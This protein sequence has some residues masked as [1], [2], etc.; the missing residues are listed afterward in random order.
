MDWYVLVCWWYV[1]GLLVIRMLAPYRRTNTCRSYVL[2]RNENNG[3]QVLIRRVRQRL[4]STRT[5]E[6]NGV[7]AYCQRISSSSRRLQVR[8]ISSTNRVNSRF[9]HRLLRNLSTRRVLFFSNVRSV[10]RNRFLVLILRLIK[11]RK[12]SAIL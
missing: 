5:S 11:R 8:S 7:D 6:L 2:F 3:L 9:R 12:Y 10:L 1:L 4:F